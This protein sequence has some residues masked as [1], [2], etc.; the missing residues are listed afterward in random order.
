MQETL[1]EP[2]LKEGRIDWVLVQLRDEDPAIENN[3]NIACRIA[4]ENGADFDLFGSQIA[5]TF[6]TLVDDAPLAKRPEHAREEL[7]HSL[8]SAAKILYGS[9]IGRSGFLAG[10][11][12]LGY[13]FVLPYFSEARQR[14]DSLDWGDVV[15]FCKEECA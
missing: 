14:V 11:N 12:H 3:V 7:A 2:K 9:D 4:E 1:D 15:E 13:T 10:P 6:G 5:I 8:H